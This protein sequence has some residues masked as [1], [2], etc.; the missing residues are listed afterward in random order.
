M[1]CSS[2]FFVGFFEHRREIEDEDWNGACESEGVRL[3]YPTALFI[4]GVKT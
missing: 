4:T 3:V 1:E 2:E